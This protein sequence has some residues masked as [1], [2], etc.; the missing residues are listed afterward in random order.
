MGRAAKRIAINSLQWLL[1]GRHSLSTAEFIAAVQ[2][3]S[4]NNALQLLPSQVCDCCCNL[5][6]HNESEDK[7]VLA[8]PTIREYL[9]S[10]DIYSAREC[11]V[12]I[13]ERCMDT[14][15]SGSFAR[16]KL[17]FYSSK[18][19]PLHVEESRPLYKENKLWPKVKDF[20]GQGVHFQD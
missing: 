2:L 15:L 7:F 3:G 13:A 16:D 14:F 5:V 9:E 17:L 18:F 1:Y 10:L 6:T 4:D 8:H 12:T 19:W 20:L 11:H